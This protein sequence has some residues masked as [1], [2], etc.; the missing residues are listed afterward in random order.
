MI[1]RTPFVLFEFELNNH[2]IK[3]VLPEQWQADSLFKK[4]CKNKTQFSKWL[5]WFDKIKNVEDEKKSIKDFQIKMV[6]GNNLNLVILVNGV[7]AGMVDLHNLNETSGEVGYWLSDDFQHLGIMTKCVEFLKDYAF[8]Q[9]DLQKLILRTAP[10]N[11]AS[12]HVAKRTGFIYQP[13]YPDS[14]HTVF[15]LKNKKSSRS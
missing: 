13:D 5:P 14:D 7:P 10:T 15:L 2:Q 6:E 8:N 4:L 12:Q 3:L 9:L 11:R 1:K